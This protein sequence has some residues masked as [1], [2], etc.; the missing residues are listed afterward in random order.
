MLV[1]EYGC[2]RHRFPVMAFETGTIS[3]YDAQISV[4]E[5]MM[6]PLLDSNN[7]PVRRASVAEAATG[8]AMP[9]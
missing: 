6:L 7:Q 2:K 9:P 4:S 3:M 1:V 8:H 5:A